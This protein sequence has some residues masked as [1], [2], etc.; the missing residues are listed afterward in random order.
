M[1]HLH[2]S[3]L[4]APREQVLWLREMDGQRSHMVEIGFGGL[5]SRHGDMRDKAYEVGGRGHERAQRSSVDRAC[6]LEKSSASDPHL[7]S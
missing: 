3:I 1:L 4:T 5:E 2:P 7:T 6:G